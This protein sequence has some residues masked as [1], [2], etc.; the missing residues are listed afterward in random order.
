[1]T[2]AFFRKATRTSAYPSTAMARSSTTSVIRRYPVRSAGIAGAAVLGAAVL[3][4]SLQSPAPAP[5]EMAS[6]D[7]SVNVAA[8]QAEPSEEAASA[9]I[10]SSTAEAA[11]TPAS[12]TVDKATRIALVAPA[13]TG[14][15]LPD[16]TRWAATG[17][18]AADRTAARELAALL[19]EQQ[20]NRSDNMDA[21]AQAFDLG[22]DRTATTAAI[23]LAPYAGAESGTAVA[24]AESET[25]VAA[26][27]SRLAAQNR[28][29]FAVTDGAVQTGQGVVTSY[30]NMR[31]APEND[32]NIL[33]VLPE[34]A[35]VAIV[36]D[37]PNWC[38]VEHEGVRGF[39]FGSFLDRDAAATVSAVE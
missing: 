38:E 33:K 14:P 11:A 39:V 2:I 25:E 22:P 8:V 5:A 26:L 18:A 12:P 30:V 27:E 7:E 32:A 28:D 35:T 20:Q 3:A 34:Q 17:Q 29:V 31:A 24:I 21:F 36:D 37:C 1:M 23:D 4:I 6:A 13:D 16:E 19:G 10:P 15:G 9:A